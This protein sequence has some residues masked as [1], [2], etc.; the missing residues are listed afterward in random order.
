MLFSKHEEERLSVR[1]TKNTHT[2]KV[3]VDIGGIDKRDEGED[4]LNI[5]GSSF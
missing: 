5:S 1:R 3:A 4:V 2:F